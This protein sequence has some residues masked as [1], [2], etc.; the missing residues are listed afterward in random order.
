MFSFIFQDM[1]FLLISLKSVNPGLVF[2]LSLCSIF[3]YFLDVLINNFKL[4]RIMAWHLSNKVNSIRFVFFCNY[5]RKPSL[6][7][8][9]VTVLESI[10]AK[11]D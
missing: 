10:G 5:H 9:K 4:V 8:S 2:S 3:F 1:S 7:I 6:R 11:S